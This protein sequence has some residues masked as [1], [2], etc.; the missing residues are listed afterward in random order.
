M[1]IETTIPTPPLD[2]LR[3]THRVWFST[4]HRNKIIRGGVGLDDLEKSLPTQP[5]LLL[6]DKTSNSHTYQA[7]AS[8]QYAKADNFRHHKKI[9]IVLIFQSKTWSLRHLKSISQFRDLN[10]PWLFLQEYRAA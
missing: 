2:F 4:G 6:Y 10:L 9:N 8:C 5:V 1:C 7:T 3:K